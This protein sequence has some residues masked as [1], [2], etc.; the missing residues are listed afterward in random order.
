M[1]EATHLPTETIVLTP[2]ELTEGA[3]T[4]GED[5]SYRYEHQR[6]RVIRLAIVRPIYKCDDE[7]RI[8][9][10]IYQADPPD[11][12]IPKGLLAHGMLAHLL[13][14]KWEDHLPYNRQERI[15]ER[16]GI[17]LDRSVMC[18]AEK[19]CA[20][21]ASGIVE[22]ARKD[23]IENACVIGTD[24]TGTLVQSKGTCRRGHFFVSIADSDYIF[25][26]YTAKHTQVAVG[27]HFDGFGGYLQADASSVDEALF[28]AEGGP[29]EVG[30]LAHARRNFFEAVRE[31]REPS[32]VAIALFEGRFRIERETRGLAPSVRLA[33]RQARGRP[34]WD[35][36]LLFCTRQS[37]ARGRDRSLLGRAVRYVLRHQLALGR[38]LHDG[39]LKLTNNDCERA[40]RQVVVGRHNWIF[41]G[42]DKDAALSAVWIS[43]L[44]SCRLHKLDSREYLRDLFR[45]LP[46]W[47]NTR[48]LELHPRSW[49]ATK[50]R[51]DPAELAAH[52]GAITIPEAIP[53]PRTDTTSDEAES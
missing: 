38:F 43:L 35:E 40:L 13:V 11:E 5:V 46:Q 51:L 9:T 33:I 20:E 29:T 32:M 52:V 1:G 21:L 42:S 26:D 4:I 24:A 47:P 2:P 22:A 25:F 8:E 16:D 7:A 19:R 37:Q 31:E 34:F 6:A 12:M 17:I 45:V 44:A 30:C 41:V 28:A 3:V 15:L 27:K 23:A 50:S 14:S 49:T 10:H 48:L 36:L 53:L 18:R 39:R